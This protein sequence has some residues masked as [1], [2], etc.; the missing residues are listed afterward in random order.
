MVAAG[1]P[2]PALSESGADLP[3]G[4]SFDA[5]TGVLSGTPA[6]GTDDTYVLSFT[7]A[8]GVEAA[9]TQSFTLSVYQPPTVTSAGSTA[10]TVGS[11]GSFTVMD[12]AP[13]APYPLLSESGALPSGVSFTTAAGVL[14]GI[15]AAGTGAAYDLT[16]TAAN[17]IGTQA[18]QNF[19]LTVD[20]APS[21]T[22]SA[23]AT[24]IGTFACA[25]TVTTGGFPAP[26]L[27]EASGDVLPS[28]V[29]FNAA[30]GVLSGTPA[31]GDAAD[32]PYI[33]TFTAANGIGCA[34]TETFILS[35]NPAYVPTFLSAAATTSLAGSADSFTLTAD[36]RPAPTL[37][38]AGAMPPG[39]SFNAA[40]GVLSGTPAAGSRRHL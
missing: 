20:E 7:A 19:V 6:A 5:A 39:V 31:R 15:P 28:G 22:S 3:A 4:V 27:T 32:S 30:T 17:G 38:E 25:V 8:N 23:S 11:Y 2:L 9:A 35:V 16:F 14:S 34:A 18:T 13:P 1:L 33:L 12:E 40:A 36:S 10:F 37:S 21:F 24:F 29:S 26:T